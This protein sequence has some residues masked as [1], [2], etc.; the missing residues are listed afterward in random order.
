MVLIS[1]Q[2]VYSQKTRGLYVN[3]FKHIIGDENN[4][5]RVLQFAKD[6]GFNYLLLYNLYHIHTYQFDIT[7]NETS[8]PLADF[9]H[10]A[11]TKYGIESIG[12]VGETHKS[13]ERIEKYNQLY[14]TDPTRRIDVYNIEF[15]FWNDKII[16]KYYCQ[17]YLSKSGFP[18]DTEGAFDF[19]FEQLQTLR[20]LTKKQDI[21]LETYVGYPT[22]IQSKKISAT[23]DRIL[24]HYYRKSDFY[25]NGNSIFNYQCERLADFAPMAGRIK[26]IPIF[27]AG[28]AFMGN[29]LKNYTVE[30]AYCSFLNGKNGF[31]A[32]VEWWTNHIDIDGFQWYRYTDL[33]K[34]LT[35]KSINEKSSFLPAWIF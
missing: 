35:K 25:K 9:I 24:L 16:D 13:F 3:N 30:D 5:L 4:E 27:H 18:C 32:S 15:E 12:V 29:W 6:Q 8:R 33:E 7:K 31:N 22:E 20:L 17:D 1:L 10:K 14:P 2:R 21:V 28:E 26:I 23:T 11:K 34:V 19:Y